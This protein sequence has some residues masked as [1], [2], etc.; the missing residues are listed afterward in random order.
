MYAPK[1]AMRHPITATQAMNAVSLPVSLGFHALHAFMITAGADREGV[2]SGDPFR[3]PPLRHTLR[4][5]KPL[6]SWKWGYR[7]SRT[8]EG[9]RTGILTG[10]A[11]KRRQST[12]DDLRATP[13]PVF[14]HKTQPHPSQIHT[15]PTTNARRP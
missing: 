7:P 15:T 11:S 2:E 14:G 5:W 1:A 6:S 12:P 13:S 9:T 8:G 10:P 3:S 4:R